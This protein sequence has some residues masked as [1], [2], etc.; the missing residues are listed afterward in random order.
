MWILRMA[1][2]ESAAMD[3]LDRI[4]SLRFDRSRQAAPQLAEA[5]RELI[6]SVELAPGTVLPRAELAEHYGVSQTPIRDALIR[7]GSEG[8]VDIFPQHAT[9]V[10][11]IDIVLAQQAHFLRRSVEQEIV[12]TLAG[13]DAARIEP[14]VKRLRQAIRQQTEALAPQDFHDFAAADRAFHRELYLAANVAPLWDLV[15]SR[16]GH[17]DR[18]RSLHLPA[19]GKAQA[20]VRDHRAIVAA[21]EARDPARAEA[22]LRAHLSGTLSFIDEICA[23]YPEYVRV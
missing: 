7:L 20:V 8:L 14:L 23:R 6:I 3:V 11:R 12:R 5:L 1:S 16:S 21:I 10:S 2:L 18:L 15:R 9:V 22:A 19:Q 4:P 17:V 13:A